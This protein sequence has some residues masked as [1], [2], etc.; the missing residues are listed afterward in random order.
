MGKG[1]KNWEKGGAECSL[2]KK[3][4]PHDRGPLPTGRWKGSFVSLPANH[5]P[6]TRG[7]KGMEIDW[8]KKN[9]A[10][11]LQW[12]SFCGADKGKKTKEGGAKGRDSR[13]V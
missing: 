4:R 12:T 3:L 13:A 7:G 9:E 1:E 11:L 6:E 10:S 8:Q 5:L 2:A